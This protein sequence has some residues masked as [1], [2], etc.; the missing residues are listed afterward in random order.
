MRLVYNTHVIKLCFI[1]IQDNVNHFT[2]QGAVLDDG[3]VLDGIDA[4]IM[5]TGFNYRYWFSLYTLT[6][7]L[8]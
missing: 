7:V 2:P 3:T 4:V 8:L 1:P 6:F 5:A